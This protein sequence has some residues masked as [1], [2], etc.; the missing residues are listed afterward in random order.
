MFDQ[1]ELTIPANTAETAPEKKECK[2]SIGILTELF[3]FFPAGCHGLARCRVFLGMKPVAPR[4]PKHYLAGDDGPIDVK[5]LIEP[6]RPNLPVLNWELWN[7]D[8][9][10][11]HTLWLG[12][13]WTPLEESELDQMIEQLKNLNYKIAQLP[14]LLR[15]RQISP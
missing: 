11:T 13:T 14:E 1:W 9:T 10:Y 3:V 5:G 4:S 8:E 12:A 7:L 15:G 2:I 6:I